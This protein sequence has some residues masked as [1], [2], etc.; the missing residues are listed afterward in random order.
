[1]SPTHTLHLYNRA[2]TCQNNKETGQ[3]TLRREPC[4][5]PQPPSPPRGRSTS[6]GAAQRR[7]ESSSREPSPRPSRGPWSL[8]GSRARFSSPPVSPCVELLL[9]LRDESI[10]GEEDTGDQLVLVLGPGTPVAMMMMMV[11]EELWLRSRMGVFY[12]RC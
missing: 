9:P 6:A 2:S 8:A 12:R 11:V 7:T 3:Q 4:P 10:S 5:T 1:M